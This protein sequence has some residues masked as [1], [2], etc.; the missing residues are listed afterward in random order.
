MSK[1]RLV[2]YRHYLPSSSVDATFELDL[3]EAPNV[4]LNYQFADIKEPEKRKAS[5]SQTFKLPFTKNN[6][7]FFQ[8]WYNVNLT[9]LV[10]STGAKFDATLYVGTIPQFEGVLQLKSVYQKG[11]YY[12]VVLMSSAANLF[13]I[14]GS[15]LLRDVFRD[16]SGSPEQ[17][18][19]NGEAN[20]TYNSTYGS[21]SYD[22]NHTFNASNIELSWNGNATNFYAI[23]SDGSQG[24]SLQDDDADVQ[25][26]IY[27]MSVTVPKFYYGSDTR[28]L[29]LT[30]AVINAFDP[31][32][33]GDNDDPPPTYYNVPITQFRPAIQ[34]KELFK[35]IIAKA[36]FSYTSTFIDKKVADGTYFGK[37][38][39]TTC[40]HTQNPCA[41]II[42]TSG[43]A[44]AAMSVG[45]SNALIDEPADQYGAIANDWIIGSEQFGECGSGDQL[46]SSDGSPTIVF[47]ADT[48]SPLS[49]YAQPYD[50]FGLW[51]TT[52]N[53][54]TRQDHNQTGLKLKFILGFK[55]LTVPNEATTTD[56]DCG[57]PCLSEFRVHLEFKSGG[58]TYAYQVFDVPGLY[59]EDCEAPVPTYTGATSY[60]PV[61]LNVDFM[62]GYT[63]GYY[64][65]GVP[66]N[67]P[68][69]IHMKV[70]NITKYPN[71][72][73][74]AARLIWGAAKCPDPLG[75][76]SV[77]NNTMSGLYSELSCNWDGYNSNVYGQ[78]VDIPS[79]IDDKLTQKAFLK[80]I[81][82]RFNLVVI[83]DPDNET[84]LIIEPYDDYLAAGGFKY[85]TDKLDL[86]K[87]IIVKDTSS[88]QKSLVTLTDLEDVDLMNKSIKEEL[89][90]FNVYGK[91]SSQNTTN[92]WASGEMKNNPVFS[93][94][95][96]NKVFSGN[97]PDAPTGLPNMVVQY[98]YSYKKVE[99]G[100]ENELST[101][102]PKLFYYNGVSSNLVSGMA[103]D[104]NSGATIH[105]HSW[106]YS[107]TEPYGDW[108]AHPFTTYPLCSPYE[109][110]PNTNGISNLI[111]STNSLYWNQNPPAVPDLYVF[112]Y[113]PNT[114][115]VLNSL[116]YA[117]WSQYFNQ[118]YNEDSRIME[119]YLNLNEV[120]IFNF[121]FND[122]IF[123][124][125][126]YW[127][128][129]NI[130]NY[131]VG[132]QAS[133]K[134]TLLK[135]I[136]VYAVSCKECNQTVTE[137]TYNTGTGLLV[138]CPD[139][140]PSCTPSLPAS[141]IT[142][143]A[144]CEC[145]GGSFWANPALAASSGVVNGTGVCIADSNSPSITRHSAIAIKNFYNTD[146][147]KSILAGKIDG[148]SYPL[149]VGANTNKGSR[150]IMPFMANDIVIK[151]NTAI[152]EFPQISG[153]SHRM[154]LSGFTL[155][156][157]RSYA[158]PQGDKN[159][160]LFILPQNSN[161]II[162]IKGISSVVGGTSSTY[163]IGHT[164]GFAYYTAFKNKGGIITQ[165]GTAGGTP[166]FAIKEAGSISVCTLY[167]SNVNSGVSFGLD[168]SQT[169]TKR[170]WQLSVEMDIN[171]VSNINIPH[172]ENWAL[173][174]NGDNI[175]L[176]NG[177]YLLWN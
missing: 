171:L 153:E 12:E 70:T 87:E 64:Y 176:Q 139:T 76:C 117:Y 129:L 18:L 37:L 43:Q 75:G 123:I 162:R 55:N 14:I 44:S 145:N 164:E 2:A 61:E 13:N 151:H 124:K 93:P 131:Q 9:T 154:V 39:M 98:E 118:I 68:V 165:L 54:F 149:V 122:Q 116:Y 175:E 134:V 150:K 120:D 25:K 36:G 67:T 173:Y 71:A 17:Y 73:T 99:T 51:N 16:D 82:E 84:N 143:A 69:K 53:E 138:W 28:Y 34:L 95:I 83:P 19:P 38:F 112:N 48:N 114:T 137:D 100:Y 111:P 24:A 147:L 103:S 172:S 167:V 96:N 33:V 166:E 72:L 21:Y 47:K 27:P 106:A 142:T 58:S 144:C 65:G 42:P 146:G 140:T 108:T 94:Y 7:T 32:T 88:M 126:S 41:N 31:D 66:L 174:Q 130:S 160:P 104:A 159:A 105:F 101:T 59:P 11:G 170:V 152:F 163:P 6:N 107:A 119:C 177:N 157:T 3:Q 35:R 113:D 40:N 63:G 115:T 158:Y 168:D 110:V 135:S 90:D 26:V 15:S 4:S 30:Q 62:G 46:N 92:K 56:W 22:L 74:T 109:L 89:P 86:D 155:G 57:D 125:D 136:D 79:C 169:D 148:F 133:T 80:D 132:G 156:N 23:N 5:Y 50:G 60:V 141:W 102:K 97:D 45:T 49:D 77:E 85:W 91:I 29:R 121:K 78:V 128:V 8:N 81:I 161:T 20:P 10:Y 52:T 1:L 127:R